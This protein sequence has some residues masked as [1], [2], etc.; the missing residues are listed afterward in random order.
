MTPGFVFFS[1]NPSLNH[2]KK[3]KCLLLFATNANIFTLLFKELKTDGKSFIFAVCRLTQDHVTLSL[4][5]LYINHIKPRAVNSCVT[6]RC[7][8][9][10]PLCGNRFLSISFCKSRFSGSV[11][12]YRTPRYVF[13]S[14]RFKNGQPCEEGLLQ[15]SYKHSSL[16]WMSPAS[17]TFFRSSLSRMPTKPMCFLFR[18][19]YD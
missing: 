8:S 1:S 15:D 6:C 13:R 11:R 5:S 18:C 2:I 7:F 16:F 9:K 3:E 17:Q 14:I 12:L 10:H 4:I 19:K